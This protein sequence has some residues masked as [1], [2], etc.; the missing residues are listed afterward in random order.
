MFRSI[1][2]FALFAVVAFL[3]LSLAFSL[4]GIVVGLAVKLLTLAAFGFLIYLAIRVLSPSTADRI[5][6]MI[7]G[8]P[9]DA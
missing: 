4:L 6:E 7:R 5:R 2:G 3:V 9:A 8:R 1:L